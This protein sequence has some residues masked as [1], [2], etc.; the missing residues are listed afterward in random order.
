M[1]HLERLAL[2]LALSLVAHIAHADIAPPPDTSGCA[3]RNAGAACIMP[4]GAPGRCVST[5]DARRP[6]RPWTRCSPIPECDVV[7]VGGVCHSYPGRPAH[8]R[9]II[10]DRTRQRH[11]MCVLDPESYESLEDASAAAQPTQTPDTGVAAPAPANTPTQSTASAPSGALPPSAPRTSRGCSVGLERST[12][13]FG[14]I[15]LAVSASLG[16]VLRRRSA[17]RAS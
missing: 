4:N 11:R 2:S 15:A 16:A 3:T 13:R 14:W 8:C 5:P 6:G 17:R 7:P 12:A 1:K 10:D 9:E